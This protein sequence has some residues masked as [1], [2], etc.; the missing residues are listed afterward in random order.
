[1][2]YNELP[3][4]LYELYKLG[5]EHRQTSIVTA[6]AMTGAVASSCVSMST[7][8]TGDIWV[9]IG[10]MVSFAITGAI[11][12]ATASYKA[13]LRHKLDQ[14]VDELPTLNETQ[15]LSDIRED[16]QLI[17]AEEKLGKLI[18]GIGKVTFPLFFTIATVGSTFPMPIRIG[19]SVIAGFGLFYSCHDKK[20]ERSFM[21]KSLQPVL[22]SYMS[23]LQ[24]NYPDDYNNLFYEGEETAK[25]KFVYPSPFSMTV[26]KSIEPE[27][28]QK[29]NLRKDLA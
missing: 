17:S 21:T 23:W 6:L 22:I 19:M 26:Q 14:K 27:P 25:I 9:R 5:N 12:I 16:Y 15:S 24:E 13:W 3:K 29:I 2:D 28:K 10:A 4:E 7:F 18:R 1:M 8:L 20:E 11:T